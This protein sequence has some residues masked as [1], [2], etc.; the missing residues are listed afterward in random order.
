MG[1]PLE[2]F[3]SRSVRVS[4]LLAGRSVAAV[5]KAGPAEQY[6]NESDSCR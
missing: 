2:C 6:D 3:H 4:P 5:N 1:F